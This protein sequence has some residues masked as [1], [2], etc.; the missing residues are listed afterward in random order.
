MTT[1]L[2]SSLAGRRV[3]IVEDEYF[4]ADELRRT[5]LAE[6]AAVVGPAGSVEE[7]L[8]LLSAN[9]QLD[10]AVLDINLRDVMIYSIADVLVARDIPFI[11][12]TGYDKETIPP[13]FNAVRHCEKPLASDDVAQAL[14]ACM[15]P[16]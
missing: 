1:T 13:R 9:P 12:A 7:A 8:A 16:Q 11:F 14:V 2:R 15:P 5:L 6:G 4:I 10:G 3:L